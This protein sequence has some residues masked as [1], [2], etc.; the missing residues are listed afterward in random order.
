PVANRGAAKPRGVEHRAGAAFQL[1]TEEM[2]VGAERFSRRR[3]LLLKNVD[4]ARAEIP[5]IEGLRD[6]RAVL[7]IELEAFVPVHAHGTRQIEMAKR[8]VGELGFDEPAI[9]AEAFV[10]AGADGRYLAAQEARRVDQ[11][12]AMR[13]HEILS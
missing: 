3:V 7:A 9:G 11:V 1:A 13:Q 6:H 10:E 5:G 2:P 4:L 8:A 12:R